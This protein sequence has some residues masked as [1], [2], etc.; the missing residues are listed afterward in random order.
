[1]N[2]ILTRCANSSPNETSYELFCRCLDAAQEISRLR[3]VDIQKLLE[4]I[5][6]QRRVIHGF[7]EELGC[8][9]STDA[10]KKLERLMEERGK[11]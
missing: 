11:K 3:A 6:D 10:I 9:T 4:T 7:V 5:D 2:D 1:M 8:G